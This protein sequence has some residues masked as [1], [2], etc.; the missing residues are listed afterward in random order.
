MIPKTIFLHDYAGHP[1]QAELSRALAA[2]GHRVIHAFFGGDQGPKGDLQRRPGDAETLSFLPLSLSAPYSKSDFITRRFQDLEYGRAAA[3][4]IAESGADI[5]ISGNT[6]TEAQEA[7]MRA[8]RRAGAKFIFWC[9][10]FYSVAVAKLASKKLPGVGPMI[11]AYYSALERRQMRGADGVVLIT[12]DFAPLALSWGV[13]RERLH[14]APNWGALNQIPVLPKDN[15]WAREH[16]LH[17]KKVF[18]YSG[19]IGLKHN[20]DLLGALAYKLREDQGA[21]VVVV[22]SGVGVDRL[23]AQKRD[24]GLDNL[25]LLGLQ[26]FE[27]L[28]ETLAT[29]DVLTAVIERDAGAFSVPSKVLSYLCAG[30]PILLA[31]PGAN[32]AAKTVTAIGAG[33]VVDPDDQNAWLAAAANLIAEPALRA[34]MGAAGRAYAEGN[35][36]LGR[37]ADRFEAIFTAAMR[38]APR[39]QAG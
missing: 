21:R 12:E 16:D 36:D 33:S 11:G 2:R 20:P 29:A 19:T 13:P 31:A 18:L 39:A 24:L 10:D 30:R 22:A 1:F 8:S 9:Q 14:I 15:A 35:F 28:P 6:P 37:V 38:N 34:R 4:A 26:K 25:L 7:V 23:R 5:V 3:A 32:L 17:D 27:R